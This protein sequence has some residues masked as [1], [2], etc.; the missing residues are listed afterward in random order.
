MQPATTSFVEF[1]LATAGGSS[2]SLLKRKMRFYTDTT[3]GPSPGITIA[4]TKEDL[5]NLGIALS[6]AVSTTPIPTHP[7][8]S[9]RLEDMEIHGDP[10]DWIVFRIDPDIDRVIEDRLNQCKKGR[11][12]VPIFWAGGLA[13]LYLA[14]RGIISFFY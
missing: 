3:D 13:I 14:G 7:D 9:I 5:V 8:G 12:V 10:W 6:N 11:F 4:G 2:L 1:E